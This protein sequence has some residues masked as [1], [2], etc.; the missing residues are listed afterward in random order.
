MSDAQ[1]PVRSSDRAG[2]AVVME[3]LYGELRE[4]AERYL[5]GEGAH[6]TLQPTALVHEAYLRLLAQ[7][8]VVW[9][10][11]AQALGLGAQAMRRVLVDHAR[12]RD[13]AKRG[14][15]VTRIAMDAVDTP[16][17]QRD[18]DILALEEALQRLAL[19]DA[20]QASIVELRFFGGLTCEQVSE[21][22]NMPRRTVDREWAAARGW[23]YHAL[24]DGDG[25]DDAGASG[26][27]HG[28]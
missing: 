15:G 23:L 3:R 28:S 17:P 16:A 13:A 21:A 26:T 11:P 4:I 7:R 6:H 14:G 12:A 2:L 10:N 1:E 9:D 25:N 20:T 19:I 22:L 8:D 5:R 18:V 27:A 24:G